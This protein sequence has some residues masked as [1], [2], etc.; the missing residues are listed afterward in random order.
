MVPGHH[1]A[2]YIDAV[3]RLLFM[4]L[5]HESGGFKWRRQLG[6]RPDTT[7]GAFG[8]AQ[9]EMASMSD[10][11]RQMWADNQ[12]GQNCLEYLSRMQSPYPVELRN[13]RMLLQTPEGDA[14]AVLF[15]RLHYWRIPTPVPMNIDAQA[16]YAKRWYNTHLGRA[17]PG[18]YRDAFLKHWPKGD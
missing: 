12:L 8:L 1:S 13:A 5:A 16:E 11:F 10:S 3:T 2:E 14:L 7:R 18:Q 4:T 6:F 17:T 9:V 15:C